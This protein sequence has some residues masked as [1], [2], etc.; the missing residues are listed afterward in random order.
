MKRIMIYLFIVGLALRLSAE[1]YLIN[2]GQA[3]T[4][5]YQMTQR[6]EPA[7]ET[8]YIKLSFVVP[9]SFQSPTYNQAIQNFDLKFNPQPSSK[10]NET[11]KR[12]NTIIRTE[13][14]NPKQPVDV[15]MTFTAETRT[16]L[17]QL[18]S[19][20]PFPLANIAS[21][22]KDY[23]KPTKQVQ[24][25]HPD[26]QAKAKS[27]AQGVKTEFDAVQRILT[28]VVDHLRYV[29]P[30]KQ[31]DALYSFKTGLGNCQNYSHLTAALM[32]VIGIPARIV[33]G[34]T[35]KEPYAINTPE[36]EFTFKMGQGRHSWIEVWF[37]DLGWVPF[38][39]Q[40]TELFVSNRFVRI[41]VGVDNNETIN[42][43]MV[44]FRQASGVK[45]KP[46]FQEV[47]EADFA[48]DEVNLAMEKQNYGPKN[49]LLVPAVNASFTPIKITQPPPPVTVPD[50]E[51]KR[52]R[53]SDK[54]I[55]GNMD[56]P[57]GISFI[58]TRGPAEQSGADEYQLKKNFLV[59]TAEYVTTKL[60]QY[61]QVV[62]LKKPVKLKYI[63]LALHKF[64]GSGQVWI[65]LMKDDNGKPG[66]V[67]ATSDFMSLAQ[68]QQKQ[69][70]DW[71]D[72]DFSGADQ[73]LSPGSYWIGLGFT[74]SPIINWFYTYGKS[75]GPVHG[76]RYKGV[77]D[78]VW[79]GAL[80]YEFNYRVLGFTTK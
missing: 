14:K 71:I 35:L 45:G 39:P 49:M 63:S 69:G 60:T 64:G 78:S 37:P 1:N 42:D 5:Q 8:K 18:E 76:T 16:E 9:Q 48:R 15:S 17:K 22:M 29:T 21:S 75:V 62:V 52:M 61:A 34:V 58:D 32:R 67:L 6:V 72:F 33:N 11:D 77:Y 54:F 47:I 73:T 31:Y 12:G 74:G 53:F 41:E 56:Y 20:A 23:L 43:G 40:Q 27:L 38:D 2:G 66:S 30:P 65:D 70:Y 51:L 44:K 3:S 57:R 4:I 10:K 79:S 46:R 28:W 68:I 26:I 13:W 80:S 36:G 55:F 19:S 7:G 24:S 50:D 59:E 25:D